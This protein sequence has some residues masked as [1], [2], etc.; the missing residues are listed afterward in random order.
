[1]RSVLSLFG[2]DF[3]AE[4]GGLYIAFAVIHLAGAALAL[5][6]VA[7]TG[8]RL[9]RSLGSRDPDGTG[10]ADRS[11]RPADMVADLLVVSVVIN[12]AAHFA[13]FRL[14][15]TYLPGDQ[16]TPAQALATFGPPAH[17]YHYQIYTIRVWDKDL[18]Q[19]LGPAVP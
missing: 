16:V 5:A 2:A 4:R 3:F 17:V 19:Q 18:L 14:T 15:N 10:R 12:V 6:A 1:V 13:A 8:W 9:V 11:G 7:L